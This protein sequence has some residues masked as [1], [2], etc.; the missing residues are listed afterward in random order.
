MNKNRIHSIWILVSAAAMVL[1]IFLGYRLS[2]RKSP[3]GL[4]PSKPMSKTEKI[5]ELLRFVS[6]HYVDK[7]DTDSLVDDIIGRIMTGLDPHSVYIPKSE[8]ESVRETMQGNFVGIGVEFQMDNDTFTIH[9]ILPSSPAQKA[10]LKSF[11]QILAVNNDTI[12]GRQIS[13]DS[14]LHLLKGKAGTEAD[15]LIRRIPGDSIFR[16]KVKRD[17]VPLISVPAAIMLND[18]TGYIKLEVFSE[19]SYDEFKHALDKL[20]QRGM[21]SLILDLRGNS[22]GYLKQAN[23]IADEFLPSGEL[24]FY[25]KN[26]DKTVK[27]VYATGRGDFEE[28][29]LYVL[30]DENTASASE[31]VAGA[32]QDNDRAVIVGRRSFGKGLVQEELQMKDGSIMRITTARY[33]TPSGRSIQRPYRNGHRDEYEEDFY[34]R[35]LNGEMFN[36]DSIKVNDSLKFKTRKGRTVYGGGG[37]VPDIFIPLDKSLYHNS[38][39]LILLRSRL[40]E[41]LRDYYLKNY[42]SLSNMGKNEFVG[43]D[44]LG[45]NLYRFVFEHENIPEDKH[46][47][48]DKKEKFANTLQALLG[49]ELFGTDVYYAVK[50]KLDKAVDTI[51]SGSNIQSAVEISKQTD[52]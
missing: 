38:Y 31:I 18:T 4:V 27:K 42:T 7:I 43:N 46:I 8:S 34:K 12:A 33:Y 19:T 10:G 51:L 47:P 28:G 6:E 29:S 15:L 36:K 30:I 9:R 35:Y 21:K 50:L 16:V 13:T 26:H 14:I 2:F 52:E 40:N 5:D 11:D 20:K 41:I 1:G 24:I 3:E 22:G 45:K 49:R 25:T 37:I 32:L 23:L 44:T 39:S 17:H 48:P